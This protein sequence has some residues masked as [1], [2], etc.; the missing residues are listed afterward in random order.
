[1]SDQKSAEGILGPSTGLKARTCCMG[2]YTDIISIPVI[3]D[4]IT[5]MPV[6]TD[7]MGIGS[8]VGVIT[9]IGAMGMVTGCVTKSPDMGGI[10]AG[11]GIPAAVMDTGGNQIGETLK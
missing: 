6:H 5:S 1:M 10:M 7:I 3:T 9:L 4:T 11:T 2:I 8:R